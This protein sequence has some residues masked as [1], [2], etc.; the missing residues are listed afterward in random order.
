MPE[1]KKTGAVRLSI[2]V[3]PEEKKFLDENQ[4]SPSKLFQ[5][6]LGQKGFGKK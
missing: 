1:K 2:S 5:W 3:S 6:A 4:F